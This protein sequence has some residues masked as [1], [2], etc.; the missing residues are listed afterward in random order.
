MLFSYVFS[1]RSQNSALKC[2]LKRL[3]SSRWKLISH[4][5][6]DCVCSIHILFFIRQFS[7][8]LII[9]LHGVIGDIAA[10]LGVIFI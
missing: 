9:T 7:I 2:Y 10:I 1:H 5:F 8:F 3:F 4:I 6:S